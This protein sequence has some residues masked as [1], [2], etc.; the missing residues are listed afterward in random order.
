MYL[1][2]MYIIYK[3]VFYLLINNFPLI[4]ISKNEGN[5]NT[6]LTGLPVLKDVAYVKYSL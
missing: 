3:Y 5:N 6:H 2:I 4:S 1:N